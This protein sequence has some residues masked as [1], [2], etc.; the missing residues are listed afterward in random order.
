MIDNGDYRVMSVPVSTD[1]D[2]RTLSPVY[3]NINDETALQLWETVTDQVKI[4][5]T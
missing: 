4:N 3:F 1:T 5:H 2:K